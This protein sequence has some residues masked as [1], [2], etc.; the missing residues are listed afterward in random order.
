MPPLVV[1]RKR[2]R[3]VAVIIQPAALLNFHRALI[4]REYQHLFG[5]SG[6]W[7]LI[8]MD[9]YSRRIIGFGIHPGDV[10]GVAVCRMF[11]RAISGP[12]PPGL[13]SSDNDPL[14]HF[15]RW[16]ADLRILEAEEIN[17]VPYAPISHPFI[18]RLI[19]TIRRAYLDHVPFWNSLDSERKLREFKN[20][21]NNHRTHSA[22]S[23]L[24]PAN[25]CQPTT[26]ETV[27][28]SSYDWRPHCRGL[29]HTLIPG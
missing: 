18:E 10:N 13:L 8:V 4:K 25:Y 29:F 2:L 7:V 17:S 3:F 24:S 15:R 26:K 28:I 19:G 11:N 12:D 5:N 14:F 16:Q 23:G 1:A 6:H 21:Y 27:N 22:L 9:Q 20:Y